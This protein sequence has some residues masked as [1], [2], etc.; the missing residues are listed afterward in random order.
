MEFDLNPQRIQ[1][2]SAKGKIILNA[3]P[4]SGKTTVIAKKLLDLNGEYQLKYGR[5]CGI[6]CL[7]FTNTAKN[8]INEKYKEMSGFPIRYPHLVSTIDSFINQNITL[9]YYYLKNKKV[10]RPKILEDNSIL[11][12]IWLAKWHYKGVD[13]KPICFAYPPHSIRFEKNGTFSSNG[14][15]PDPNKVSTHTFDL[16]CNK[17]KDWQIDN[18]LITTGDSAYIALELLNQFPKIGNWLSARFPHIIVDEAQ[19]NSDIQHAIFEK[20]IQ[21]G[22]IRAC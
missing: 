15:R 20:L 12:E 7:S 5:Y 1:Y 13:N 6:A 9:P 21:Q 19:D 14:S 3:C 17:I 22:L 10:A 18:G 11:D 8:E 2:L 16:Y 4:G